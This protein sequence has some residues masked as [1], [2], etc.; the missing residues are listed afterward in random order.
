MIS[1]YRMSIEWTIQGLSI[2]SSTPTPPEEAIFFADHHHTRIKIDP[3]RGL[4]ACNG[5][6]GHIQLYDIRNQVFAGSI[7]VVQYVR[8]SKTEKYTRIY[9]PS[10]ALFEFSK[11]VHGSSTNYYLATIDVRRGEDIGS[12]YSLKVF[13]F[14]SNSEKYNQVAQM[15]RPHGK[16]KVIGLTMQQQ[17]IGCVTSAVDGSIKMWR[18]SST[19][20]VSPDTELQWICLYTLKYRDCPANFTCFSHDNSLFA[21]AHENMVSLWD[22]QR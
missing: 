10:V 20:N 9:A 21:L 17:V 4:I 12:E 2:P 3:S 13:Q 15:D 19:N 14:Q 1:F 5:Y 11:V 8:V 7:E 18:T 22:P 6:P 16:Y